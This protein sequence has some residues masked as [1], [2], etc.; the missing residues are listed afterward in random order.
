MRYA[1]NR[2]I[3]PTASPGTSRGL[4]VTQ[5]IIAG[6]SL[7]SKWEVYANRKDVQKQSEVL[8]KASDILNQAI[9]NG[10]VP[11]T[12]QTNEGLEVLL[13]IIFD[14]NYYDGFD[15]VDYD[16]AWKVGTEILDDAGILRGSLGGMDFTEDN[17]PFEGSILLQTITVSATAKKTTSVGDMGDGRSSSNE[18]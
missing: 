4:G 8:Q 7:Y 3:I 16:L 18:N 9:T 2:E 12:L 1:A 6:V 5:A 13:H 15:N 11:Q 17:A 14:G 10:T